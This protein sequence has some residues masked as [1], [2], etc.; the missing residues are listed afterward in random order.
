M[1]DNGGTYRTLEADIG[2]T[3]YEAPVLELLF[4]LALK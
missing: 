3:S 2:H 1:T 4:F